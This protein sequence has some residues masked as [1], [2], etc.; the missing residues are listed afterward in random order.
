MSAPV[1]I[2]GLF[3]IA[4]LALLYVGKLVLMPVVFALVLALVL[5][6]TVRALSKL[7]IPA[8]LASALVLTT[9]MG[10]A[11][12]GVM[13]LSEPAVEWAEK[14]PRA[15][16]MVEQRTRGLRKPVEDVSELAGSV[17]RLIQVNKGPKPR[18]VALD[19]PSLLEVG[20]GAIVELITG[21]TVMLIALYFML[22]APPE[23]LARIFGFTRGAPTMDAAVGAPD[24]G[25]AVALVRRLEQ[26][27]SQYLRIVVVINAG[28]G[29]AV[30][31][32]LAAL[33]MPNPV[34]WGVLAAVLT[35]VPYLGPLLGVLAVALAS[36][37]TFPDL[38]QAAL[39]PLSY[40]VLATIE[41][42]LLTPLV[43]GRRLKI[44]PL[45]LF[46]WLLLWGALWGI[47]GAVLAAPTLAL[48]KLASDE[49]PAWSP[50]SR[51]L[52]G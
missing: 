8:S 26:Q 41:G 43:L 39:P 21:A 35:F 49:N 50:L 42:N 1:P 30:G 5:R 9:I 40:M 12:V 52:E 36:I 34:L 6:P 45:I 3:L 20:M 29:L 38:A 15:L 48:I 28:L 16:R 51:W 25:A 37:V 32:V 24:A 27:V 13:R 2:T 22:I 11:A 17:D 23:S 46:V 19:R 14:M 7:W 18:E 33:G 47:G 44:H 31:T 10:A 4:L